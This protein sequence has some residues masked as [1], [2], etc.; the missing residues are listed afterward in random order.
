MDQCRMAL[1]LGS[2]SVP[3][4]IHKTNHF[5]SHTQCS[6]PPL[7]ALGQVP[8]VLTNP[9][10]PAPSAASHDDEIVSLAAH[11]AETRAEMQKG[12]E[13]RRSDDSICSDV[14]L[15]FPAPLANWTPCMDSFPDV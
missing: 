5:L 14:C 6:Q 10:P 8:S 3:P 4:P 15:A 12:Q 2:C 13:R 11:D 7:L 9:S 1:C